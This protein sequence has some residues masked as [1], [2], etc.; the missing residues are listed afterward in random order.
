VSRATSASDDFL[1]VRGALAL[2][3]PA[4]EPPAPTPQPLSTTLSLP[5]PAELRAALVAGTEAAL[6]TVHVE[7]PTSD[8][9]RPLEHAW[10]TAGGAWRPYVAT[11]DLVIRDRSFAW[12][13]ERTIEL[14]SRVMGDDGT[15]S[16]T[17]STT[18]TIDWAPP[19]VFADQASF[20][21][22]LVVPA[23]DA[24]SAGLEWAMG[25]V[26]EGAP[27]TDW[28][29]DPN[30]DASA[31]LALGDNVLVYVRDAA[32]NVGQAVV[33]LVPEPE[34]SAAAACAALALIRAGR[35]RSRRR[36]A[37]RSPR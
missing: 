20:G 14:R 1:S 28:T 31:A 15:T 12:Q 22:F 27:A 10:R 4:L 25:R 23:R 33:Q 24:T 17:G 30:L 36:R 34:A 8:G 6:P 3:F 37:R 9:S 18:V 11:G 21:G 2:S 5:T 32:G 29:S 19:A 16:P 13:G 35:T 7:L 26:G